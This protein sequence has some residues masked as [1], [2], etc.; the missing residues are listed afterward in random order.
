MLPAGTGS[1][2]SPLILPN[3]P[4]VQQNARSPVAAN[5]H[6]RINFPGPTCWAERSLKTPGTVETAGHRAGV[7]RCMWASRG[8]MRLQKV[9]LAWGPLLCRAEGEGPRLAAGKTA[10]TE[11]RWCPGRSGLHHC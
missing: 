9:Q 11:Q 5:A 1:I 3:T 7:H 10:L 4:G 6:P 2:F 8:V